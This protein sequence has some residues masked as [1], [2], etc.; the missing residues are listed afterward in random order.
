M[1]LGDAADDDDVQVLGGE[2]GREAPAAVLRVVAADQLGVGL[3]Q[4][5]RRAVGLREAGDH[6][7]QEPDEPRDHVPDLALRLDDR[8]KR[9][10]AGH[11]DRAEEREAHRD[12]VGDELRRRAHSPEEAVL[13]ARGPAPEQQAVERDRPEREEVEDP[14]R[15]VDAVE[16]EALLD[17]AERDDRERRD[18]GEDHDRRGDVVQGGDRRARMVVLLADQLER[19]RQ[20]LEKAERPNAVGPVARLEAAEEL[21]LQHRQ[22]RHDREDHRE[23]H[24]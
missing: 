17:V 12:L 7:D 5:E 10:R 20:R 16:A 13:G 4:V 8:H 23:D 24:D 1:R 18:P 19:V 21:P 2:V 11:H 6:E 14:D 9:Q 22:H 15:H 3:R